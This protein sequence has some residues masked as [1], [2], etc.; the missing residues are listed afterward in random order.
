MVKE[1]VRPIDPYIAER[2]RD[3][4]ADF[5]DEMVYARMSRGLY[6]KDVARRIGVRQTHVHPIECGKYMP[7]LDTL[8]RYLMAIG[9]KLA[10]VDDPDSPFR[11]DQA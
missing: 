7:K 1:R 9:C 11:R 6:Q 8:V 3:Y 5:F 2:E 4:V 10:I